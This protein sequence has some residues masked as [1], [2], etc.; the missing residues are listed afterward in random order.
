MNFRPQL[1]R[2][3]FF[4]VVVLIL[5]FSISTSRVVL[6]VSAQSLQ[7]QLDQLNRDLDQIRQNK[8]GIQSQL[9]AAQNEANQYSGQVGALKAEVDT[10]Q[11][12]IYELDTQI[13]AQQ[14]T[15]DDLTT[16]IAAKTAE[17]AANQAKMDDLSV[18]TDQRIA[19]DYQNYRLNKTSGADF[20][21][22]ENPNT[23]FKDSQ[24]KEI[25]QD[26]ANKA[27]QE[28]NDLQKQMDKDR[29]D[30]E[31]NIAKV[32]RDKTQLDEQQALIA[33]QQADLA[34]KMD[35]YYAAYSKA[36]SNANLSKSQLDQLSGTESEKSA[37][38]EYIRQQLFNSFS[39]IS[40]GQYV[41]AGTMIGR[42]GS[43]GWST[44][45]HLHFVV[46]IN[47]YTDNPC[48]Y[49][50]YN[51]Y[52]QDPFGLGSCSGN[53]SLQWPLHSADATIYY[54]STYDPSGCYDHGC[55]PHLALDI[56]AGVWN[57]PVYAAHNGYLYKG[58][59]QYGANYIILCE[60]ASNCNSG[61]KTGYWHLSE[62]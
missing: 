41:V 1:F 18:E 15:I 28:L 19:D 46:T 22:V 33:D 31:D 42:Q 17:I 27:L 2:K 48:N 16:K 58:V 39:S 6:P 52:L 30:L 56:A 11:L 61:F 57:S 26:A 35:S 29:S 12:E 10:L 13:K 3:I 20:F 21:T 53:G 62:Y 60:N 44:G 34:A 49:L 37:Q 43:T 23:Y 59:D 45:P 8:S 25:I 47:G 7:D 54:T 5:V 9:D 51:P 4:V 55:S 36:Q 40:N 32:Q 50:S 38:A 24:Y 14:L